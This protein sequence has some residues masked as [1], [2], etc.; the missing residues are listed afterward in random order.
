MSKFD[1]KSWNE[2]PARRKLWFNFLFLFL[3]WPVPFFNS[4][5]GRFYKKTSDG[6]AKKLW[7]GT[8]IAM[9]CFWP[10]MFLVVLSM[11]GS[12]STGFKASSAASIAKSKI[13]QIPKREIIKLVDNMSLVYRMHLTVVDLNSLKVASNNNPKYLQKCKGNLLLSNQQ[14]YD[15]VA[16]L[17]KDPNHKNGYLFFVN[18][19]NGKDK[20]NG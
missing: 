9:I 5:T 11:L 7:V 2:I 8:N 10:I 4:L 13:C 6:Q 16:R 15:Y 18:L 20:N 3:F 14:N 1:N 19:V 17:A 12:P